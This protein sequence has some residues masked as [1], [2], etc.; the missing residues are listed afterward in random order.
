MSIG[1]VGNEGSNKRPPYPFVSKLFG[2]AVFLGLAMGTKY[3]IRTFSTTV[4]IE[5]RTATGHGWDSARS[6]LTEMLRKS[7]RTNFGVGAFD[8]KVEQD[9]VACEVDAA[10]AWLNTTG[11]Y[12]QYNTMLKDKEKHLAEQDACVKNA[13]AAKKYEEID[14][15]CSKKVLPNDWAVYEKIFADS[16][17]ETWKETMN[18]NG[19][20]DVSRD[21]PVC[22]A[23][24][25]AVLLNKFE[26]CGPAA[27]S[28]P[29]CLDKYNTVIEE[30][31]AKM[32]DACVIKYR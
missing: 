11:C 28:A 20:R 32:W 18:K 4:S 9:L 25:Y 13:G 30:Q 1:D 26:D 10:I 19:M 24:K 7:V 23:A 17:Y 31:A 14:A 29:G 3:L 8:G 22:V 2:F 5:A 21:V 16:F 27:V 12:Y 6:E 15:E